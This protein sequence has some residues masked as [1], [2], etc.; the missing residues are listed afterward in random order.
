[1]ET[2]DPNPRPNEEPAAEGSAELGYTSVESILPSE[3]GHGVL[4][5]TQLKEAGAELWSIIKNA[6]DADI[7]RGMSDQM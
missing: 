7:A 2:Q 4:W 1:M 6:D 5:L 3:A